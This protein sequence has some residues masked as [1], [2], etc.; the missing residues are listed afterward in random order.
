MRALAVERHEGWQED[1]RYINMELL[2]QPKREKLKVAA[3]GL[4]R[5]HRQEDGRHPD[6]PLLTRQLLRASDMA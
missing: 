1:N 2:R 3:W 5:A 6:P 4:A